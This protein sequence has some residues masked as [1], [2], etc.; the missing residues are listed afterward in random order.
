M[1]IIRD[2]KKKV[3]VPTNIA[4]PTEPAVK[5]ARVKANI[6]VIMLPTAAPGK[7]EFSK[8]SQLLR[9]LPHKTFNNI[10]TNTKEPNIKVIITKVRIDVTRPAKKTAATPAAT[11]KLATILKIQEQTLFLSLYIKIPPFNH[12]I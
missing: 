2:T 1:P 7:I 12:I 10:P 9:F 11:S 4:A 3:T 6:L 8:H 5:E